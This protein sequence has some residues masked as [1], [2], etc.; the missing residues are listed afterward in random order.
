MSTAVPAD[1]VR[2]QVEATL[3]EL[4]AGVATFPCAVVGRV[5]ASVAGPIALVRS[6]VE[7]SLA[8][9]FGGGGAPSGREPAAPDAPWSP[10]V[11]R[12][13]DAAAGVET[14][15]A[16]RADAGSGELALEGYESL[17]A[18]QVVARLERLAPAEL[19]QIRDFETNHRGR[20]TILGKIDQLLARA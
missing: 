17:A 16:E 7:L 9:V 15:P 10:A 13:V 14:F 4:I 3:H 19:E 1:P 12:T 5:T 8:S 6:L 18:S 20:R 2:E 11:A